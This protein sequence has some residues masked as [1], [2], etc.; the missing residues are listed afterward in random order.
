MINSIFNFLNF[1]PVVNCR[2]CTFDKTLTVPVMYYE[3][4]IALAT[5]VLLGLMIWKKKSLFHFFLMFIG[6]IIFET[7]TGPLWLNQHLGNFAYLYHGV[8]WVLSLGLTTMTYSVVWFVDSVWPKIKDC[9]RFFVYLGFLW[10]IMYFVERF[11]IDLDIRSYVP[12]VLLVVKSNSLPL[13]NVSWQ[14]MMYLPVFFALIIAFYKYLAFVLLDKKNILPIN[15]ANVIRNIIITFI[16]VFLFEIMIDP[17]VVNANLP[18]WSYFYRDVSIFLTGGWVIIIWLA[19]FLIDKFFINRSFFYRF[20]GYVLTIT[21][22]TAPI[23]AW[24]IRNNYR[25]Y[26]ESASQGFSGLL[27]PLL[28]IPIEVVFAIP[29]YLALVFAFVRYWQVVLENNN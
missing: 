16:G 10:P 15:K 1:H 26:G 20:I 18:S 8:S 3:I 17:L 28:N 19:I 21:I 5:I 12:E 13:I 4:F 7:F 11:V 23:E 9:Y 29:F 24:L 22:I 6:V 25:I 2:A 14:A 27:F